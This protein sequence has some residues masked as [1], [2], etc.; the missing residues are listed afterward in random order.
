MS[1]DAWLRQATSDLDAAKTLSRDGFHSQAIWLAAQAVEKGHKAILVALG[2]RY[3]EKHF[4][5]F[6]HRTGEV[7]DLL[8]QSLHEPVDLSVAR[9]IVFLEKRAGDSRYPSPHPSASGHMRAPADVMT[10]SDREVTA[11]EELLG[12]CKERV[13]RALLATAAMSPRSGGDPL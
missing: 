7:S 6:G 8:P 3:E 4:K 12:W 5:K 13:T 10:S 9:R 1:H 11:A 2:L